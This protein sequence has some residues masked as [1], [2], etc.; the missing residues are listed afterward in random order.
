[1]NRRQVFCLFVVSLIPFI[2]YFFKPVMNG[3]DGYGYNS[4]NCGTLLQPHLVDS[5]IT[6]LSKLFFSL[7]PCS[8]F[9]PK[10]VGWLLFFFT[11]VILG[12]I[13]EL[14]D[15]ERGWLFGL[16]GA[17]CTVFVSFFFELE[18]MSF[19]VPL[20]FLAFYFV[21]RFVENRGKL[22]VPVN[23]DW[24]KWFALV[25]VLLAGC[26]WKGSIFFLFWLV[27]VLPVLW[28]VVVPVV[29]LFGVQIFSGLW[30]PGVV[31]SLPL[32]G[33]VY[34]FFLN[35][36]W[37]YVPRRY[38]W[39]LLPLVLLF[40]V[41]AKYLFFVVPF[42]LIGVA[43]LFK[44]WP[45]KS[46]VLFFVLLLVSFVGLLLAGVNGLGHAPVLDDVRVIEF[47]VREADG[48]KV[49][50]DWSYG[51]WVFYFGGSTDFFGGGVNPDFNSVKGIIVTKRDE[52]VNGAV[53]LLVGEKLKVW[54]RE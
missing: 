4:Y 40:L 26:F 18:E 41:S 46:G 38:L 3:L 31:E 29:V 33:L 50:N 37:F 42:L 30:L 22:F 11:L 13:G 5:L 1:M 12:L 7:M 53:S 49:F 54:K 8:F 14:F 34:L 24:N 44:K 51:Y 32:A 48:N 16:F 43:Q 19:G 36:F 47:A 15:F 21:F 6:P 17:L 23:N 25:C 9:W 35:F 20:I 45:K 52:D 10:V 2:L 27:L 28:F 39:F